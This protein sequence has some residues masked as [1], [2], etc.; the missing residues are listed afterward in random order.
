MYTRL[1]AFYSSET[2]LRYSLGFS[3]RDD[4]ILDWLD[5]DSGFFKNELGYLIESKPEPPRWLDN[6]QPSLYRFIEEIAWL[7]DNDPPVELKLLDF[8]Y[9]TGPRILHW[10]TY[11]G[12]IDLDAKRFLESMLASYKVFKTP[13][14]VAHV[15]A[16]TL[17]KSDLSKAGTLS[18]TLAP[19][20]KLALNLEAIYENSNWT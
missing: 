2:R 16:R 14:I 17:K 18:R 11:K 4:R 1:T 19:M 13:R 6:L 12:T 5:R 10:T 7:Y 15:C 3:T 9:P 8:Y 20:K